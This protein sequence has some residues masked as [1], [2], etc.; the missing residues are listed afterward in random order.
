MDSKCAFFTLI[1]KKR[2]ANSYVQFLIQGDFLLIAS[3]EDIDKSNAWNTALRAGVIEAVIS[4]VHSFN[5]DPQLRY[6]WP[7][8]LPWK[9]ELLNFFS[10]L[11][12]DL[13]ERISS[14]SIL[15]SCSG[16]IKKPSDL[17]LIPE[18]FRD[19]QNTPM[20]ISSATASK[21]LSHTY[22]NA[23]RDVLLMLGATEMTT[24]MFLEDLTTIIAKDPKE[25][26]TKDS[27]WHSK[28]AEILLL[29]AN[30]SELA[31]LV[32]GLSLIPLRNGNVGERGEWAHLFPR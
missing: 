24:K 18:K 25:I 23:D 29:H 8:Y 13:F 6:A 28:L 9:G 7:R 10:N 4:A 2:V 27:Q 19:T 17:I 12:S 1:Y 30:E 3:R 20:T 31:P 26:W 32:S 21:Y 11:K 5:S 15:E 22:Q 16:D 14:E